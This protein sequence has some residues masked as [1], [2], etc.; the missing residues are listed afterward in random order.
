[1]INAANH[2]FGLSWPWQGLAQTVRDDWREWWDGK[3]TAIGQTASEMFLWFLIAR[4]IAQTDALV[5]NQ[6]H[7]ASALNTTFDGRTEEAGDIFC[8]QLHYESQH[9]SAPTSLCT[10]AQI[11]SSLFPTFA[12]WW[13]EVNKHVPK[14]S[15]DRNRRVAILIAGLS[16][17][18]SSWQPTVSQWDLIDNFIHRPR[19]TATNMGIDVPESKGRWRGARGQKAQIDAYHAVAKN[20]STSP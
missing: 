17:Q 7:L 2:S 4:H 15:L 12:R 13:Y 10:A 20:I 19:I 14:I 9:A 1:M 16:Q 5:L 11:E 8:A 3:Q 6:T 18:S